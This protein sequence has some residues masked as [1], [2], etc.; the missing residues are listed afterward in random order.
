MIPKGLFTQIAL[1]IISVGII[2]TYI[3]PEFSSVNETQNNITLYQTENSKVREVNQELERQVSIID[4]ISNDDYRKLLTYMPDEIDPIAVMRDLQFIAKDAGVVLTS[5]NDLGEV[6]VQSDQDSLYFAETFDPAAT[7]LLEDKK[8]VV[9]AFSLAVQGSYSQIK[10]L[11]E[12]F[13]QNNY[14]MVVSAMEIKATEGGFLDG[15]ITINTYGFI[16][17]TEDGSDLG[18]LYE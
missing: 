17:D 11:I 5:V 7:P 15:S 13:E 18:N 9:H 4:S 16:N 3:K 8:P 6:S 12:R 1:V 10:G 14:P 2:I